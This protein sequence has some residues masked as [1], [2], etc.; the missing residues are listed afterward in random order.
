MFL[1]FALGSFFGPG[2]R[3]MRAKPACPEGFAADAGRGEALV[4]KLEDA[5]GGGQIVRAARETRAFSVCFGRIG[6]SA[7]TTEGAVLMDEALGREEG[8][9]RLGHLLQHVAR[10]SP[11]VLPKEG[12]CEE[13]TARAL[14]KEAEA[15]SLELMLRRALGVSAPRVRYEFEANYWSTNEKERV[16][17]VLEYLRAHPDGAPGIDALGS[18]YA[19]RCREGLP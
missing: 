15:L 8:A 3:E 1:L 16:P 2:C 5:P 6:V 19:R 4:E 9:A 11:L 10:G 13:A 7:V 18:A 17:L 14:E 12:S